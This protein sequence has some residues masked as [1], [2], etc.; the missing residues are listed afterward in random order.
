MALGAS[1]DEVRQ[2]K[3]DRWGEIWDQG[4]WGLTWE[5]AAKVLVPMRRPKGCEDEEVLPLLILWD[6]VWPGS[7]GGYCDVVPGGHLFKVK[8]PKLLWNF[9]GSDNAEPLRDFP[10]LLVFSM[11]S[12][13]RACRPKSLLSWQCRR[14]RSE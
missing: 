13:L 1:N 8:S 12:Y 14:R 5:Q 11:S 7:G 2:R 3:L 10:W 9:E 4:K 6:V